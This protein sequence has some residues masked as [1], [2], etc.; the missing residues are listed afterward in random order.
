M[1]DEFYEDRS[2][3]YR[4]F[5][6]FPLFTIYRFRLYAAFI[7][8]EC[9]C[10]LAG[11]GGYPKSGRPRPGNG[12]TKII[13]VVEKSDRY[14]HIRILFPTELKISSILLTGSSSQ[15]NSE[16]PMILIF[17]NTHRYKVF[18]TRKEPRGGGKKTP[19]RKICNISEVWRPISMKFSQCL[20]RWIPHT[21]PLKYLSYHVRW[22]HKL[23]SSQGHTWKKMTWPIL[24][25]RSS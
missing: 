3:L 9:A 14:C 12:P 11:L 8:S 19:Q 17:L 15:V 23:R 6:M 21:T 10:I 13:E 2:V 5:Y 16:L 7:S 1:S 20:A 25:I 4:V 22:P 24:L 18:A